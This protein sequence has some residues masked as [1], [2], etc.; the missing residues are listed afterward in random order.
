[1]KSDFRSLWT[2]EPV[3]VLLFEVYFVLM[4][5]AMSTRLLVILFLELEMQKLERFVL[6]M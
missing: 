5:L 4:K 6:M 1:M 2:I 3:F